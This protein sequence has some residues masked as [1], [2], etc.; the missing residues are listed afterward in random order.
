MFLNARFC[1]VCVRRAFYFRTRCLFL[2]S[3]LFL[4]FER[5]L[6][7]CCLDARVFVRRALMFSNVLLLLNA[8]LF[9]VERAFSC[10]VERA[11]I[12]VF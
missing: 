3:R 4:L 7:F 8:R 2:D 1:F 5:A 11:F 6:S 9:V 12:F 10:V